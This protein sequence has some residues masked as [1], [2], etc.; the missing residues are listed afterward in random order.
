[1]EAKMRTTLQK[2]K[3]GILFLLCFVVLVGCA[4]PTGQNSVL[5]ESAYSQSEESAEQEEAV[6]YWRDTRNFGIRVE[7]GVMWLGAEKL[8]LAGVNCYNLFNQCFADGSAKEAKA[9]LD[10]LA[11]HNEGMTVGALLKD[12]RIK[13]YVRYNGEGVSSQVITGIFT[14]NT[15][16]EKNPNGDFVRTLD[17]KVALYSLNYGVEGESEGE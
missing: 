15:V 2:I 7:N 6:R 14:K 9:T 17:K 5:S 1:M 8:Y 13:A 4:V 11:E 12:E 16:S 3:S 10:I